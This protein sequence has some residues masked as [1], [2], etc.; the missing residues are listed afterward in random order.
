MSHRL[1]AAALLGLS[2][3]LFM[4]RPAES[5][6]AGPAPSA[7]PAAASDKSPT[8]VGAAA[9][10]S[11]HERETNL[12][13]GSHH[14]HAME[15]PT[16]STVRGNFADT[17]FEKDG[18]TTTFF[19]RGEKYFVRSDGP[20]GKLHDYRVAYTFGWEPLQ[21]YLLE[22]AGG[23]MQ[24]LSIAWDTR[25]KAEGGQR[26]FHLYPN[27]KIDHTDVLH[28][29]GPAQNWNHMCAECHSTNL[30]KGYDAAKDTFTTTWSEPN[31]A[32]EACHGPA[33]EHLR[34]AT[35]AKAGRVTPDPLRGLVFQ[36]RDDS[37][38][39]WTLAPG[40]RIAS[41]TKPPSSE[42]QIETC[43]RCHS[44]RAQLWSEYRH[45]EP[46]A[47]THLVSLLDEG[48]YQ[49][50]GQIQ[51]EVYEYGSFLQSKMHAAGVRCSD[52]HDPHSLVLRA[53]GNA[54]CTQ[55]HVAT[56]YD[57][58]SHHFHAEGTPAA[59]C[60]SCHMPERVYMGVDG[61]R[62]HG[63][64]VPRPDLSQS[65]G[66]TNACN[67]CHAKEEP[68]WAMDAL[69]RRYGAGLPRRALFAEALHAGRTGAPGAHDKLARAA[70]EPGVPA[71]ARAT[72]V[73]LLAAHAG[74]KSMQ[75]LRES[76]RDPD[77]LVRRAAAG[78]IT[79]VDPAERAALA[80][81]LLRDPIR[82]VRIEVLA[83]LLD[84]PASTLST[85][86]RADLLR[87]ID[88]YRAVQAQSMDRA[89]ARTN[90]GTLD[91]RLGNS[92]AARASFAAAIRLQPTFAPAY[93]NLAELERRA[94]AEKDAEAVLRRGVAASPDVAEL[95]HALGLALVRQQ[96]NS[97][98]MPEL[99]KASTL[100]PDVT[101]Y[102]YVY[103]VAL[104]DGGKPQRAIQVL[105]ETQ[106]RRP[107]SPEVLAALVQYEGQAG[108]RDAA[109]AWAR[110][111][112]DVTQ[113]PQVRL[114][115]ERLSGQPGDASTPR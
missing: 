61:R 43:A 20:D 50:D 100:A 85:E 103:A 14:D 113:D 3:A 58:K 91:A 115:I 17:K 12:W 75:V 69:D 19:R 2:L 37:G 57:V 32:C 104:H 94:G 80:A 29:T 47:Q 53:P 105:E 27:E 56:T 41:R 95:H 28:W 84:A 39:A 83:G 21:Q 66:T 65:Y 77:P 7:T 114:L 49:A 76:L 60:V 5:D 26:W 88:E 15:L 31:V 102:A 18:V 55:C 40:A 86:Q 1:A 22:L 111:L 74:P 82:T 107:G 90:A 110:K 78:A 72:A 93:A 8:Y 98:A 13:R 64:R 48:T 34:W 6:T 38:S 35:E 68:R 44:R 11:C 96:R 89:D 73:E 25:P 101:R 62:D 92:E 71:I 30:H 63:F 51:D 33:A 67:D 112:F 79:T 81:P 4:A 36:L 70:R 24:A 106:Q 54:L 42:A 9:C 109:L 97:E 23:R 99:A 108:N 52:C 59:R 87:V 46:L 16:P 10:A 45:G